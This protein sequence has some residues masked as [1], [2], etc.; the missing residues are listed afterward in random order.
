MTGTMM[1]S[2][3]AGDDDDVGCA[4]GVDGQFCGDDLG[5]NVIKLFY[6]VADDKAQSAIGFVL[7][8]PFQS[9]LRI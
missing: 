9:G 7:G 8:N 3:S 6:F 1:G 5:G 4:I 2:T